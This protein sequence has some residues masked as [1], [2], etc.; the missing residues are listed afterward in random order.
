MKYAIRVLEND[1]H[2]WLKRLYLY[3]VDGSASQVDFAMS[4]ISELRKAIDRL[5][6]EIFDISL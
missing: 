5:T 2:E 6:I 4:R 3:E 1:L